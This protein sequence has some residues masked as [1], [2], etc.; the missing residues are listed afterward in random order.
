MLAASVALYWGK[1][2]KQPTWTWL[3]THKI[4]IAH[5]LDKGFDVIF[6][7]QWSDF[8]LFIS[9]IGERTVTATGNIDLIEVQLM[10]NQYQTYQ[11][12]E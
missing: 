11:K 7:D 1:I 6:F 12:P 4:D 10:N 8:E 9:N 5:H 2:K 3:M